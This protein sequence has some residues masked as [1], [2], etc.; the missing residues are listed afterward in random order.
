M[1]TTSI[2][3][4]SQAERM[5]ECIEI[6]KKM[7]D[8]GLDAMMKHHPQFAL[9][10]NAFV[11]GGIHGSGRIKLPE[12]GRYLCYLFDARM[13]TESNVH[14]RVIHLPDRMQVDR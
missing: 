4:K 5:R 13:H 11:R 9:A 10:M 3:I 6:R 1:S 7:K 8:L 14:L 12:L 2:I